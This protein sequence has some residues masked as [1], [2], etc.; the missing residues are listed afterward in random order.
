MEDSSLL[1]TFEAEL[2]GIGFGLATRQEIV[3]K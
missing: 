1:T 2:V 3:S